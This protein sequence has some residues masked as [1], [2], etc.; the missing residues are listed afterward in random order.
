APRMPSL[1]RD[2]LAGTLDLVFAPICVACEKPISPASHE[3]GICTTCWA[4]AR[5]LPLPRCGRCW[6]PL[7]DLGTGERAPCGFCPHLRAAVRCV[8]SSYVHEGPI[9]AIVHALKYRGW[10]AI[11]ESMGARLASVELPPEVTE[12]V[13]LVVPVPISAAR[14]RE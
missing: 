10:H 14:R 5:T 4:R 2:I 3:R 7:R 12:E 1:L 8:R 9:R 6:T 11:A 13:E